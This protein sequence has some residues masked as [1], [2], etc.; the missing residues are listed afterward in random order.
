MRP[1]DLFSTSPQIFLEII[2]EAFG[3]DSD[4]QGIND[5][6]L[7]KGPYGV[8]TYIVDVNDA[9]LDLM[10]LD[11]P[12]YEPLYYFARTFSYALASKLR[13]AGKVSTPVSRVPYYY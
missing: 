9:I 8:N 6:G 5:Y 3:H 11:N 7:T 1:D 2:V 13:S 10:P 12:R 4:P